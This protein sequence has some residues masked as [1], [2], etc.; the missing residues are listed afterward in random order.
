MSAALLHGT[1]LAQVAVPDFRLPPAQPTAS[2]EPERQ[3]PV[4]P[5]LPQSRATPAP[6]PTPTATQA[7]QP[8]PPLVVPPA[9]ARTAAPARSARPTPTASP[10]SAPSPAAD[11]PAAP[12]SGPSLAA[13]PAPA[14]VTPVP[15][16]AISDAPQ[17][18]PPVA[19][20]VPT[21]EG[22]EEGSVTM[23]GWLAGAGLLAGGALLLV[24]RRRRHRVEPAQSKREERIVPQA[25]PA[26]VPA[27][28]P[29]PAPAPAPAASPAS[30]FQV[31]VGLAGVEMHVTAGRLSL[32]LM[33]AALSFDLTLRH[34]GPAPLTG[35]VLRADMI[36]AHAAL[37]Q[38]EQLGGPAGEAPVIAQLASLPPGD[39]RTIAAEVRLPLA[40][41]TA[42]RQ[43]RS[44]L[45]V[46]LLRLALEGDGQ[47]RRTLTLL[48][49]PP[50]QGGQVQPVR[51]DAGPRVVAP[52]L[53]RVLG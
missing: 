28:R 7:V 13:E 18:P 8:P 17:S 48:V 37:Q 4:A 35:L 11:R 16:P 20:P 1:A 52:L 38:T 3:G 22:S 15:E 51:L 39:T 19:P 49:G 34:A 31:D 47:G 10:T 26:P 12:D 5:D 44:S 14:P 32:S 25:P 30:D 40:Q 33:N 50:G 45:F 36:G 23:L 9:P 6:S 21:A 43:G 42:I 29:A 27:P 41:V 2:P 53:A 46:P 24:L